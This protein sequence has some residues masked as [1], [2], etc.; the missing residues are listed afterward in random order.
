MRRTTRREFMKQ[1][2]AGACA[3]ILLPMDGARAAESG[4]PTRT[5]GKTGVKVSLLG[6]GGHHIGS[7]RDDQEAIRFTRQA[8]DMGVTFMDNAWGYHQGRSEEIMGRALRDGYRK[9]VFLMTKHHGRDKKTALKHLDDSLRRLQTDVIDLWQFH[10]VVY[11]RD[12]EM[13]FTQGGIEAAE[14]ARQAGKVRFIGFTGHKDPTIHLDMLIRGYAWDAVQMP[15]NVMDAH[16]RSF[17]N[18]I[19]PILRE[20]SIGVIAMKSL[21]SRNILRADV[22][23][24]DE[25]INYVFSQPIDTL[26]SGMNTMDILETNVALARSFKPMSAQEQKVVLAKTKVAASEGKY[27]PFKTTRAFDSRV[28]RELHGIL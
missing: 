2:A 6:L 15:I 17:L 14:E 23:R 12:P 4:I 24:P 7:I 11:P 1:A 27:E 18:N 3:A 10:E 28:G 19:V 8:I 13:I 9:K 26:I 5:L 22:I 21:A 16:F 20:R 25:A